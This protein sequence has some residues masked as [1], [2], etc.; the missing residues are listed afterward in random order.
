MNGLQKG[1]SGFFVLKTNLYFNALDQ[2]LEEIL[3]GLS[4]IKMKE[5]T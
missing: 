2:V 4:G 3:Q 1:E 5:N